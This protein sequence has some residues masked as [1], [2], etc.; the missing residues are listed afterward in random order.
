MFNL[1]DIKPIL[2]IIVL[3]IFGLSLLPQ[4]YAIANFLETNIYRYLRIAIGFIL[5]LTILILA[6]LKKR[7]VGDKN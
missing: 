2:N 4:N 6:N 5:G 1:S 7:K 3:L